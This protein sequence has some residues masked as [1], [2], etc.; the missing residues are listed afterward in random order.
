LRPGAAV[1]VGAGIGEAGW[2]RLGEEARGQ[3]LRVDALVECS[4]GITPDLPRRLGLTQPVLEPCFLRSAE[5]RLRRGVLLW[6]RNARIPE[7]EF[8]GR[9]SAIEGSAPVQHLLQVFGE[10]A[11]IGCPIAQLVERV[12]AERVRTAI[13]VL[14]GNDEVEV[15]AVAKCAVAD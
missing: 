2:P 6:V 5:D 13:A 12:V 8:G 4:F 11:I 14:I 15:P 7:R 1:I 10:P 3:V 9:V